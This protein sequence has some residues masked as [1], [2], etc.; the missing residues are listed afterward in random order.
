ML[1]KFFIYTFIFLNYAIKKILIQIQLHFHA[2]VVIS[3]KDRSKPLHMCTFYVNL[4]ISKS[5]IKQFSFTMNVTNLKVEMIIWKGILNA[6]HFFNVHIMTSTNV[7]NVFLGCLTK[8][9]FLV[10]LKQNISFKKT[11]K[12]IVS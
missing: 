9:N 11:G 6:T 3:F 1:T 7:H 2:N 4:N 5:C 8:H 10:N 12:K